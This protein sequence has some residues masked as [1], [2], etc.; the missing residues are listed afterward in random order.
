MPKSVFI[1]TDSLNS[2]PEVFSSI[3]P[4]LDYVRDLA[5]DCNPEGSALMV[6]A[7]E[8]APM[9]AT[10]RNVKALEARDG[11]RFTAGSADNASSITA[12]E[13]QLAGAV[14]ACALIGVDPRNVA[15]VQ[16]ISSELMD[17]RNASSDEAGGITITLQARPLHARKRSR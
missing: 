13:S 3:D 8:G 16:E 5:G 4:A 15:K 7:H 1:V 9:P 11:M 12:L 14:K 2:S 10:N 6:E 17:L